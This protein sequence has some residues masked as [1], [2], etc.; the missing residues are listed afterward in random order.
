M[1]TWISL[2]EAFEGVTALTQ[3]TPAIYESRE[4]CGSQSVMFPT[5]P[6]SIYHADRDA[7]SCSM[8]KPLLVSP[9]HFQASLVQPSTST[10]AKNFGSL[11]HMLLLEP[12]NV[13]N[14]LAVYPGVGSGRD[15]DFKIFL[16]NNAHRLAVDEPTFDAARRLAD[17]VANSR[18][19][20]RRVGHF[21]E[22]SMCECSIY[23]TEPVTGLRLRVRFD[24]YHPDFSFDLKTTRQ[25]SATAFCRDAIDFGYDLQAYMYSLARAAFEGTAVFP[26]FVFITA[27]TS[28]P[29]SVCTH[30]AGATF[31]ENGQA[32]LQECLATFKACTSVG[33]WPDLSCHSTLEIVHWQQFT[34]GQEWR[35][36]AE[37][38]Q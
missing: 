20:G 6:N 3:F 21:L 19:R 31:L 30:V 38:G 8:L 2:A 24:A 29:H 37:D 14:E 10:A 1:D 34:P 23:F 22:E 36:G 4:G 25:A 32:K 9:A 35:G 26:P 7:L 33:H 15:R 17:K 28:A 27:E 11:V 18:L 12:Q 5:L 13:S 16:S